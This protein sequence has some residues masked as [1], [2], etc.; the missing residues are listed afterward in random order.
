M[1]YDDLKNDFTDFLKNYAIWIAVALVA[2]IVIV[3]VLI[4]F[5]NKTRKKKEPEIA[6]KSEWIDALGGED[7]IVSSEA[8]GSRLSLTLV[9]KTKINREKLTTLGVTSVIEMSEKITLLLEDKAERV[10]AEI[11]K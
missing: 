6:K 1:I 8:Y 5:L 4:L 11:D 10:K 7:N 3:I 2:V 9:D